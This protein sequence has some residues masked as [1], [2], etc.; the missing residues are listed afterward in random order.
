LLA[1]HASSIRKPGL[2]DSWLYG[3]AYRLAVR[4]KAEAAE[5]RERKGRQSMKV[6]A[7]TEIGLHAIYW[8]KLKIAMAVVAMAGLLGGG[9]GLLAYQML[10]LRSANLAAVN[11]ADRPHLPGKQTSHADAAP[12]TAP[13]A[14][15]ER[16]SLSGTV[17]DAGGKPVPGADVF[18]R[19]S[20]T[21]WRRE[22]LPTLR[23]WQPTKTRVLARSQTDGN[24]GFS[25][26]NIVL[27]KVDALRK[28]V[29]PFDLI[30]MAKG[31]GLAWQHLPCPETSP[32]RITLPAEASLGGRLV[33]PKGNPVE[34]ARVQV[35][36]IAQLD[37][38]MNPPL[39][40]AGFVDLQSLQVPLAT[41][42]DAN[43]R[44]RLG[45]LPREIRATLR[46]SADRFLLK[47][48]YAATTKRPQPNVEQG[49]PSGRRGSAVPQPVHTGRFTLRL[50]PGHRLHGRV[51][52]GDTGQPV[53]GAGVA[54]LATPPQQ[55]ADSHG[56][57]FLNHLPAG[58]CSFGVYP[59]RRTDYLGVQSQVDIPA[60]KWEVEHTVRLP[61]GAVVAGQ[62][63]DEATSTGIADV[64]VQYLPRP[65]KAKDLPYSWTTRSQ[66]DGTFRFAV[67]PGIGKLVIVG[68]VPG[69]LTEDRAASLLELDGR[70]VREVEAAK[71][72]PLTGV[73]FTLSRGRVVTGRV[74]APDGRSVRAEIASSHIITANSHL[75]LNW[76]T[77]AQGKFTL[78]GLKPKQ[79]YELVFTNRHR[80]L[81]AKVLVPASE[82]RK[83]LVL[84]VKSRPM[85][86][87]AGR[88]VDEN[89]NPIAR[90]VAR[91]RRWQEGSGEV[92]GAVTRTDA[93]GK[94]VFDTLVPDAEYSVEVSADG[95]SAGRQISAFSPQFTAQQGSRH[96]LAD[97]QLYRLP[98]K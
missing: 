24:G 54:F 33:D 87:V 59:P 6:A 82:D 4:A 3:A 34:G 98:T 51:V 86:A 92:T 29:F 77:D 75:D 16:F 2:V 18:L 74:Q 38:G 44:F 20:P 73:R 19:E 21:S 23:N 95:Y 83:P 39:D 69:Y 80:K 56:R 43:G 35:L 11:Q 90:A 53:A 13:G 48:I 9:G 91:L 28:T 49:R 88:V 22:I 17:F 58:R 25:F 5:R 7:L 61:R 40:S 71:N 65:D 52:F 78:S 81:A 31:R 55:T 67:P 85:V 94:F 26:Q 68:P 84:E 79:D 12:A 66:T 96:E 76:S 14:D 8:P 72:R 57:F 1:R 60:D 70:W 41:K 27:Y 97:L 45:G 64:Q 30:V 50:E 46:C 15:L 89:G 36:Q 32:A 47:E 62:V 37:Q 10:R 63:V 42:T 93:A